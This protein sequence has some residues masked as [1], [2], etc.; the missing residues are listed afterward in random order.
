MLSHEPDSAM[1]L[2]HVGVSVAD[3]ARSEAFYR[4]NLAFDT[5]EDRFTIADHGLRGVVLTNPA[6][7]RIELFEKQGA[8]PRAIP[9]HPAD[10]AALHG[11]FQAAFR[12]P[13][14]ER[15]FARL[16]A[17][18]AAAILPPFTAPDGRSRVAFIADPDGNLIELVER[19]SAL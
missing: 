6:G 18:G 5:V 7:A 2:D 11:W 12:T 10:G 16:V 4:D 3:L 17:V 15:A 1:A 9:L 14:V 19:T 8:V 13:D